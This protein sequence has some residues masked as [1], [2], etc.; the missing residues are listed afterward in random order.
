VH[1][2]LLQVDAHASQVI[3]NGGPTREALGG[4]LAPTCSSTRMYRNKQHMATHHDFACELHERVDCERVT[5]LWILS[6]LGN[7]GMRI[8]PGITVHGNNQPQKAR[9]H[10]HRTGDISAEKTGHKHID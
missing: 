2:R 1:V 8:S 6:P 7:M 10:T 3:G 4:R 9:W 5:V